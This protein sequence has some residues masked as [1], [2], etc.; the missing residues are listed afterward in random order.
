[1]MASHSFLTCFVFTFLLLVIVQPSIAVPV[2]TTN[3]TVIGVD[4]AVN[5]VQRFLGIPFA[6]PPVGDLR[7]RQ[8]V[9]LRRS[10]GNLRAYIFGPSCYSARDQGNS[11]ED[12]LTLNIW[13]PTNATS[14]SS[15]LPVLVWL[16][17]GGLTNGY[18]ADP[19][20]EGTSVARISQDIGKPIILVSVNY[21]LGPFG[22][23]NGKEMAELGLLNI[24]MLDQ[25]RA[26]S[27]IQEN[28]AAFGGDPKK[29]TLAGESAGAVSIYSHMMAYGGRNDG[30]FRGAILQSGGAFP[31]TP[32]NTTAFQS[33]FDS[34]INETN[35]SSVVNGSASDKLDCIRKLPVEEFRAKV[36]SSTGQSVDGDFTRT[37]IQRALPAGQYIKIPTVVGT[38]TDEGTTSAPTGINTTEQLFGSVAQGYFRPRLLPNETVSKLISLYPT[39]PQLG[40]P[41]NTGSTQF[42]SGLLDKMACSIFGDIVQIGPARMIA[43]TLARDG[44]PVYRYRFNHLQSNT[45]LMTKG[46]GTGVEQQYVF[47]NLIPDQP[48]D[49]SMAY[50]MSASWISFAHDL[51]PNTGVSGTGLPLWPQYGNEGNSIVFNGYGSWIEADTYR[52]PGVQFIID[53][54]LTD[55]AS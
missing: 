27:W 37:S 21:R 44:V 3:G 38:N 30:L 42:T 13:R 47:S 35:C 25:R 10:F 15:Q 34:L 20:F 55:G 8:A 36:G 22:F 32:P 53:N 46:I 48:W 17:G 28:I 52:E 45:S 1:M 54:V 31:L 40:C 16:Y 6:E 12:C 4:D 33:T 5:G 29:V 19:R 26:L 49:Q 39:S 43:Q 50:Q 14:S 23:L 24:G 9:S 7:L 18:T 51:D 41:Y 11:S 2:S